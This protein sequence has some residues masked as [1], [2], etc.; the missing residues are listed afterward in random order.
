MHPDGL[1]FA[2]QF[3]QP[4]LVLVQKAAFDDMQLRGLIPRQCLFAGHSLGEYAAL[5]SAVPVLPVPA[6][7][8]L[9]FLRGMVM[10]GAV[11]R[12]ASGRSDFG[13]IACNPSR[14]GPFLTQ[15]VLQQLV[16]AIAK[17]SK[18]L[19]EVV[20]FNVQDWQY[21]V[22]GHHRALDILGN[23][24]SMVRADPRSAGDPAA[25]LKAA[26]AATD[27][28]MVE[29]EAAGRKLTLE[30][31]E[32]T[33]P[34]PGIDVPF[35]SRYLIGGV[36]GFRNVLRKALPIETFQ[37]P[38]IL[39]RM[40][41]CYIPNLVALPFSLARYY[42]EEILRCTDSPV[43]ARLLRGDFREEA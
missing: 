40:I 17:H 20:N 27:A 19:L 14:V 16:S 6:L 31:G 8:S 34:I 36:P 42:C 7:V 30:R 32:A 43:M 22:A 29:A 5:A 23:A 39:E 1:L 33:I 35:H 9:V 18:S 38:G 26:F 41:G 10:Q 2:T 3:T 4:A 25:L 37:R 24:L 12:D 28:K 11:P 21:V 15:A 13:M